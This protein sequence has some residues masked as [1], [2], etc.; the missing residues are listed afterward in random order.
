MSFFNFVLG[1]LGVTLVIVLIRRKLAKERQLQRARTAGLFAEVSSVLTDV[2]S[3][4]GEAEGSWIFAG[5]YQD[6]TFHLRSIIDTLA[7]RKLPS[8]W[9]QVTLQRAQPVSCTID[10]MMRPAGL[11]SFSNFD[12]LA[13]T[14]AHP[15]GAPVEA[16]IKSDDRAAAVHCLPVL[17]KHFSLLQLPRAKELLISPNGLR[18]V[19]QIGEASRVRYG[20]FRQADFEGAAVT[21]E[22]LAPIL[23]GLLA[24]EANLRDDAPHG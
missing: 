13:Y 22:R 9:L 24:L 7:T 5:R 21:S 23:N 1:L 12:F 17:E 8:L 3:K 15:A 19:V 18:L 10:V 16:V 14:L 20:V 6:A 11:T 4:P 2:Q